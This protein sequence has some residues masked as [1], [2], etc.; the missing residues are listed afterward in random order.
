M[1]L[2]VDIQKY[3]P[4]FTLEVAFRATQPEALGLLGSSGSGKSMTLRCIAGIETPDQGTIVLNNRVLY[5]SQKGINLPSRDRRVG[6]LFQHY[7]LFPHLTVAEN[8]AYGLR[9]QSQAAIARQVTEQLQRVQLA[10]FG[11]RYPPQLSG[12]QQ[13]RVALARALA[14][15]PEILLLDEPFSALDAHLRSELEKQLLKTLAS[16][17]GLTLFVSHNLEEAYRVCPQLLVLAE[18]QV[19]AAGPKQRIF[20]HPER[21]AVAQLT[22]CKN[23]S[24]LEQ[25]GDYTLRALDWDC[26]LDTLE[27]LQLTHTHVGIRAHRF[28]FPTQPS[29]PN[30]QPAWLVWTS[31][32]PHRIS[33]YL[34]LGSPPA[35]LDDYHLQAEVFKDVWHRLKDRPQPWWVHLDPAQL[36]LLRP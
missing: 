9:G 33:L 17:H 34:K 31:E 14:P 28:T 22:G 27:P 12:G 6:Y 35:D 25:Q 36:L 1:E 26:T 18:G 16:Y 11:N 10:E 15:E 7:A 30:T 13:Q 4:S 3:L 5:D 23:L 21:L 8:I 19:M 24:R 29:Q 2:I 20:D 32:S